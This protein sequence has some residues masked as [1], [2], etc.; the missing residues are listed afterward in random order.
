MRL[1]RVD[2]GHRRWPI[3]CACQEIKT[4]GSDSGVPCQLGRSIQNVCFGGSQVLWKATMEKF[5]RPA[6]Q[7]HRRRQKV[8][9]GKSVRDQRCRHVGKILQAVGKARTIKQM[10]TTSLV[11]LETDEK[12]ISHAKYSDLFTFKLHLQFW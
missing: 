3:I 12:N 8:G 10:K 7:R 5:H 6:L 2:C 11:Y 4:L 1:W 9:V